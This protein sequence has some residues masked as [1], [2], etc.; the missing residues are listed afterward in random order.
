MSQ[1]AITRRYRKRSQSELANLPVTASPEWQCPRSDS[2]PGVTVS[3]E[4]QCPRSESPE[5]Q[6]VQC[7]VIS[8]IRHVKA[9]QFFRPWHVS[10]SAFFRLASR[11]QRRVNGIDIIGTVSAGASI[12]PMVN[13]RAVF[14]GR[15]A[16]DKGW[17][18]WT[19]LG[20]EMN[21]VSLTNFRRR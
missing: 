18:S 9:P 8:R 13:H 20:C 14:R 6:L 11:R 19:R 2:I 12:T 5:R 4:W 16:G 17:Q 10:P 3:P 21:W 15:P 1:T 7:A